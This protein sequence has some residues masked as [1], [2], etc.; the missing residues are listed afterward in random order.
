MSTKKT[1]TQV[2][3][4][5]VIVA[6]EENDKVDFSKTTNGQVRIDD[7]ALVNVKSN[8]FGSLTYIDQRSGEIVRWDCCGAVQPMTFNMLR[9]MKASSA[10]FFK[11]QWVIITGFADEN[12]E[13]YTPADI[14]KAL[15]ITNYYKDLIEPSD[16][17]TIC[18]WSVDEIKNKVSLMSQES[19]GNLVVALNT[20]IE[21]GILDS[22]KRIK[23]F[24][25]VLGCEL[26]M[27]E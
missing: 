6:N 2:A 13:K 19:R 9:S 4:D 26:K 23:A 27:P 20:Y 17:M 3:M 18:S 25:A 5:D 16:Y 15:Y 22:L 24:E 21:R 12:A 10:G 8:V 7:S 11:N 1:K 14:Y